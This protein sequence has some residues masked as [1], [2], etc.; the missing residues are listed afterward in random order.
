MTFWWLLPL[1]ARGYIN[2]LEISDLGN[3]SEKDTCRYHYDQFLFI[4]QAK[5]VCKKYALQSQ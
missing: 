5:K 2:P 1:L 3:L 4:Y